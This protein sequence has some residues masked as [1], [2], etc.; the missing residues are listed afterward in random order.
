MLT[1]CGKWLSRIFGTI[2][3]REKKKDKTFL[4][5]NKK[6]TWLSL[7][8]VKIENIFSNSCSALLNCMEYIED[9]S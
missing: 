2:K 8:V 1:R 9:L 4:V 5:V 6:Q 3:S 7:P